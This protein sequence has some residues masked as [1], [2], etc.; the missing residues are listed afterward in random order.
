MRRTLPIFLIC[1]AIPV[2]LLLAL[3][4]QALGRYF[5]ALT[6]A[7]LPAAAAHLAIAGA[8][9]LACALLDRKARV[10]LITAAL[11]AGAIAAVAVLS[12]RFAAELD[13]LGIDYPRAAVFGAATTLAAAGI[14]CGARATNAKPALATAVLLGLYF[15]PP[16]LFYLSADAAQSPVVWLQNASPTWAYLDGMNVPTGFVALGVTGWLLAAWREGRVRARAK[17]CRS[18]AAETTDTHR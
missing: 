6:A 1:A 13:P 14:A 10:R 3:Q 11:V 5:P 2:L 17:R 16:A 4:W 18:K 8:P 12:L 9:L 7:R 15:L